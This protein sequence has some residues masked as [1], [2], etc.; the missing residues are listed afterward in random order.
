M[1]VRRGRVIGGRVGG[2][3]ISWRVFLKRSG[4]ALSFPASITE[5]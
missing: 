5:M 3:K 4:V 2:E 1:R